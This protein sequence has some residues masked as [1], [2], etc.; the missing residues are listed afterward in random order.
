MRQ[1]PSSPQS[2][3]SFFDHPK[4][5]SCIG[6]VRSI[7]VNDFLVAAGFLGALANNP[8]LKFKV[9]NSPP[10]GDVYSCKENPDLHVV[11]AGECH[12]G[13]GNNLQNFFKCHT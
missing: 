12:S 2:V 7:I 6:H 10:T 11:S 3:F 5:M 1:E 8:I 13:T 4:C 9:L